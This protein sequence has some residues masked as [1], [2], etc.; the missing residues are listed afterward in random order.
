MLNKIIMIGHLTRDVEL[1]YMQ[2]G[3]AFAVFGL[4]SNRKYKKQDGSQGE[5]VCFIDVK[6]FGRT[7]EI[8]NQFLKKGSKICIEG[9]LTY[10]TW[11]DNQGNKK[12]KHTITAESLE[13]LDTLNSQNQNTPQNQYQPNSKYTKANGEE[14]SF[15][16]SQ[17]KSQAQAQAQGNYENIPEIDIDESDIPF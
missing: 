11:E 14:V 12:S 8:A 13:M 3:T 2:S 1:K 4:A 15:Q 5:D 6:I 7:A 9:K 10:E 17:Q 16:T